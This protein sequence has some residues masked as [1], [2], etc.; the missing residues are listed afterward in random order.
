MSETQMEDLG[1]TYAL[2][3]LPLVCGSQA[4][5]L[6]A[7]RSHLTSLLQYIYVV[8][9]RE[10]H[11]AWDYLPLVYRNAFLSSFW[12]T[13][14]ENKVVLR[15]S[16]PPPSRITND[17]GFRRFKATL[18][19][20]ELGVS[21]LCKN[22]SPDGV[23]NQLTVDGCPLNSGEVK[24]EGWPGDHFRVIRQDKQDIHF[25]NEESSID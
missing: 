25:D 1:R 16:D 19:G 8:V 23:L 18:N 12:N 11:V 9:E 7:K 2:R 4:V 24:L 10:H 22:W 3:T 13:M 17:T 5:G 14:M 20:D 15:S 21:V 6:P